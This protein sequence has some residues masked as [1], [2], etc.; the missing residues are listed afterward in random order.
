MSRHPLYKNP[1]NIRPKVASGD[2]SLRFDIGNA[3]VRNAVFV[4]TG[5][6]C[7]MNPERLRQVR[8]VFAAMPQKFR[9]V[10][11]AGLVAQLTTIVKGVGCARR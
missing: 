11:H 1:S 4:P 3:I 9:K 6:R 2:T 5:D 8:E 10:S 7:L